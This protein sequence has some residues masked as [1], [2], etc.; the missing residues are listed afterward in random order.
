VIAECVAVVFASVAVVSVASLRFARWIITL[1]SGGSAE[2][3]EERASLRRVRSGALKT[4]E[5][6][7][8]NSYPSMKEEAWR[9]VETMNRKLA[10]LE[11][12]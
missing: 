6:A 4:Y 9:T 3:E 10:E 8:K 5:Y 12:R 1:E 7:V 2:V 11:K